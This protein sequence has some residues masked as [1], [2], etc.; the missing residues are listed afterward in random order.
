MKRPDEPTEA[1]IQSRLYWRWG[2]GRAV[3]MPNVFVYGGNES[4]F[5]TITKAGYVDEYEIKLSRSD[6]NADKRKARHESYLWRSPWRSWGGVW[7][8]GAHGGER[9]KYTHVRLEGLAPQYPNRFWYVAPAGLLTLEDLPK[10]AGLV[11]YHHQRNT[12]AVVH[13]APKLHGERA[14]A[15]IKSAM[16]RAAYFRYSERWARSA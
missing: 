10:F 4:D 15:S 3:S 13:K 12:L 14:P 11:E 7:Y 5:L 8:P 2:V 16:L 9:I 6:F 1:W